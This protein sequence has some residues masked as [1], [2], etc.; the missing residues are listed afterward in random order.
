MKWPASEYKNVNIWEH[1]KYKCSSLNKKTTIVYKNWEG[2][3]KGK[4]LS[5]D[6]FSF[7][8]TTYGR[9]HEVGAGV[10]KILFCLSGNVMINKSSLKFLKNINFY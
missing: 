5:L 9:T 8:V 10:Y 4:Y 1:G 7:L 6:Q 3:N 2:R